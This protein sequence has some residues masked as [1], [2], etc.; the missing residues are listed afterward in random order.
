MSIEAN[1]NG[2]Q[3]KNFVS[4]LYEIHLISLNFFHKTFIRDIMKCLA[5]VKKS[6]YY[7]IL[8][9]FTNPATN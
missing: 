7:I 6:V 2:W 9:Q 4:R 8:H 3:P 5:E 1:A